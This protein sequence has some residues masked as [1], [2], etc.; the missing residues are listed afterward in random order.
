[1]STTPNQPAPTLEEI[2]QLFRETDRKFQETD[3]K[4]QETR[5][6]FRENARHAQ[7]RFQNLERHAQERF[8][9]LER[10]A[11]ERFEN[12]ERLIKIQNTKMGEINNRLGEFV[13][14]MVKP[15][16]ARL[17]QERDIPIH[18]TYQ[19][20]EAEKDGLA[21]EIDFLI[22]NSDSCALVEVK[23]K[24]D[25]EDI[26]VHLERM[27]KFKRLFPE[28]ADKKAYGAVAAMVIPKDV[29]KYAYRKG[30]FVIAQKGDNIEFLNDLQFKPKAW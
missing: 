9:N 16:I 28:Y 30:F 29:A 12:L 6:Q 5:E 11:Q 15:G 10:H 7:E 20:V 18:K 4:F 26:N 8:E 2:W 27:D 23:S 21:T 25:V 24:L 19:D 13:E 14:S 1:M 22:I 17:F 3:K